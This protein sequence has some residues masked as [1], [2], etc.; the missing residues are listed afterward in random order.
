ME[1]DLLF[2]LALDATWR[3]QRAQTQLQAVERHDR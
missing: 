2:Q 3:E 1:R